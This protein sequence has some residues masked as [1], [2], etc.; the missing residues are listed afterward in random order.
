MNSRHVLIGAAV[1][2]AAAS[3]AL[4]QTSPDAAAGQRVAERYCGGCHAITGT[5]SPL[6]DAPPFSTIYRRYPPGGLDQ[7]LEEGMLAP[8]ERP[9]EGGVTRLHPRMPQ[10][11]LDPDQRSE[12]KA[13]LRSLEPKGRPV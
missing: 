8:S 1:A 9:E 12:L 13:Y 4:S 7:I 2:L 10:V 3:A 6:A 11:D 5:K